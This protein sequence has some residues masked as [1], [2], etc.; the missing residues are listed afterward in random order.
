MDADLTEISPSTCFE[1][2][3]RNS[4]GRVIP[5]EAGGKRRIDYILYR[6]DTPLVMN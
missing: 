5:T 2:P 4:D 3:K 6:A 1:M